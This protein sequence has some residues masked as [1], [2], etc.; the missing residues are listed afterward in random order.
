MEE[1]SGSGGERGRREWERKVE[2]QI[3]SSGIGARLRRIQRSDSSASGLPIKATGLSSKGATMKTDAWLSAL[4]YGAEIFCNPTVAPGVPLGRAIIQYSFKSQRSLTGKN[5][6][7]TSLV[8]V[9][10]QYFSFAFNQ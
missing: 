9:S 3:A 2:D 1:L 10:P 6:N 5:K 4:S 8:P 7:T